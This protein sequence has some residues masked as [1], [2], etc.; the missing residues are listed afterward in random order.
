MRRRGGYINHTAIL[1]IEPITSA[2]PYIYIGVG[3]WM[4]VGLDSSGGYGN[5]QFVS[6]MKR[7]GVIY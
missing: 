2:S 3:C 7:G 1:C 5:Y 6:L 4:G